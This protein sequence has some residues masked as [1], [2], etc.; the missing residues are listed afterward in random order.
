M[1]LRIDDR[2]LLAIALFGLAALYAFWFHDDD[3]R[4]AALLVFALPPALLA[5]G[6]LTRRATARF[7]AG[8]F[9]LCWF[10]HGVM[11]AWAHANERGYALAEIALALIVVFASSA[12]G[13]RA[14]FGRGR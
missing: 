4:I 7:W 1:P 12:P 2:R 8:V 9:A 13:L 14:R 3:D 11:A 6:V 5:L 10:S